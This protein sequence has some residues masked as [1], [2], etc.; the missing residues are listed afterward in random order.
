MSFKKFTIYIFCLF[1]SIK[2][3]GA[4]FT[5]PTT[6]TA[7]TT[8]FVLVSNSGTTPAVSGFSTDVFV[9]VTGTAGSIKIL[10]YAGLEQRTGYCGYTADDDSSEPADCAGDSID[11][12]DG[13][14]F[15]GSQAEVNVALATLSYKGDGSTSSVSITASATPTG[16]SYNKANGHY[17]KH[18]AASNVDFTVAQAAAASD[19][20]KYNGLTGYLVTITSAAENAFVFGKTTGDAWIGASDDGSLTENT[21][22]EPEGTWEW[23]AGPE[24]GETFHCQ[25]GT[26]DDAEAAHGDCTVG[27][28]NYVNWDPQGAQ[29]GEPNDFGDG[30]RSENCAHIRA[31]DGEWNDYLCTNDAV[32]AYIIE[33]GG[34]GGT[35]TIEVEITLTITSTES[36]AGFTIFDV[37][38]KTMIKAQIEASNRIVDASTEPI[39][40][41]INQPRKISKSTKIKKKRKNKHS[42]EFKYVKFNLL[43]IQKKYPRVIDNYDIDFYK[44]YLYDEYLELFN[45]LDINNQYPLISALPITSHVYTN[46]LPYKYNDIDVIEKITIDEVWSAWTSGSVTIGERQFKI[47][48]LGS[49]SESDGISFGF[50][51]GIGKNGLFGIA[52]REG[53][54]NTDVGNKGTKVDIKSKN[55]TTYTS[56]RSDNKNSLDVIFGLGHL[57]NDLTRKETSSPTN[58]IKGSRTADQIYGIINFDMNKDIGSFKTSYYSRIEQSYSKLY[59]YSENSNDSAAHFRDQHLTTSIISLGTAFDYVVELDNGGS[60]SPNALFEYASDKSDS[61]KAVAYYLSDPESEYNFEAINDIRTIYTLGTGFDLN[62]L[63]SW[64]INSKILRKIYKNEGHENKISLTAVKSF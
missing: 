5:F 37:E 33:Y 59:A 44:T 64:N 21:H 18:V 7:D 4:S 19:D 36:T 27:T 6:L 1:F 61:S 10:T 26:G 2:A 39:L 22:A 50:D 8:G 25:A 12:T 48:K 54:D 55:I 28:Y 3:Y 13:I 24:D 20:Q 34:M 14:G 63:N 52:F 23:V 17:Y 42:S 49:K 45:K 16:A 15:E 58:T 62:I 43:T 11:A 40:N 41:R 35:A 53:K 60:F 32:D 38:L 9:V 57:D 29:G 46:E 56:F 51:R 31:S 47:G 30:A